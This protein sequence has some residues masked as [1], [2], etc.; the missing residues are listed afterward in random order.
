MHTQ[1]QLTLMIQGGLSVP[2]GYE[3]PDKFEI[4]MKYNNKQVATKILPSVL[5]TVSSDV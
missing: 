1:I 5:K 4:T 3:F 2:I